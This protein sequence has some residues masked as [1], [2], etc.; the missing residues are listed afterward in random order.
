MHC[1]ESVV[2]SH[3]SVNHLITSLS[4]AETKELICIIEPETTLPE[5]ICTLSVR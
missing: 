4:G 5:N 3:T 2:A 1:I